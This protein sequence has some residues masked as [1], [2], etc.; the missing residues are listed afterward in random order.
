MLDASSLFRL[1]QIGDEYRIGGGR[2]IIGKVVEE[3]L[4]R[5]EEEAA[6]FEVL[7]LRRDR[8]GSN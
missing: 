6:S 8:W 7:V 5:C 3:K 2:G 4:N 1:C